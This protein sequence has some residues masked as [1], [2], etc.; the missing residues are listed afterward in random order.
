MLAVQ[1][2]DSH[3]AIRMTPFKPRRLANAGRSDHRCL[4]IIQ[5]TRA[6]P[7]RER[8]LPTG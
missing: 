7:R 1:V 4:I 8:V 2:F 3:L 6:A 5:E